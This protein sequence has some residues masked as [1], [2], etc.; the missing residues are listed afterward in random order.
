MNEQVSA[1]LSA[2]E[3]LQEAHERLIRVEIRNMDA[4][5]F[6]RKYDHEDCLFYC[7]PPYLPETRVVEE[8]YENEMTLEQ[9]HD[10]LVALSSISGKFVLS[11]YPSSVYN[12]VGYINR[13]NR[14]DIKID[15]KASSAAVKPIK[16]ECLW[17]NY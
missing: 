15:S 16:T 5:D 17:M 4:I 10:L 8:S 2:V 7:D 6:I 14:V 13:W 12:D 11:G 9:H 1:W 3:G